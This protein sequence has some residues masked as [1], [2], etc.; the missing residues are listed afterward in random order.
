MSPFW[1][2]K[3]AQPKA[4]ENSLGCHEG[5]KMTILYHRYFSPTTTHEETNTTIISRLLAIEGHDYRK[6]DTGTPRITMDLSTLS[7]RLRSMETEENEEEKSIGHRSTMVV[8]GETP[9]RQTTFNA[10][11]SPPNEI[12]S[13]S[14]AS[15]ENPVKSSKKSK[16]LV[17]YKANDFRGFIFVVHPAYGLL[18]LQC[19][20]KK[21]K[22]LHWQLPGGHIDD[23]EFEEAARQSSD[24]NTQLL[25]AGKIGAARELFEETGIDVRSKLDRLAPASLRTE[26]KVK[27]G[28]EILKNEYNHRLFYL[29]SVTDDD[30]ATKGEIAFGTHGK[31]L[32][33]S[34]L[35]D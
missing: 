7:T 13:P 30:F 24:K 2:I 33:V 29:L 20:R 16:V 31:H 10:A 11:F 1:S 8:D 32:K 34:G 27:H 21:N 19:T 3:L 12:V 18:L 35:E 5:H 15:T 9:L 17:D 23:P 28:V 26:A 4:K 25:I 14:P 6:G 22:P